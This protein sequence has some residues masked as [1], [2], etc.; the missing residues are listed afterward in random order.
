MMEKLLSFKPELD[1]SVEK[2]YDTNPFSLLEDI[3]SYARKDDD[4][5][6]VDCY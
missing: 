6:F 3:L 1:N 4:S 5:N 2:N